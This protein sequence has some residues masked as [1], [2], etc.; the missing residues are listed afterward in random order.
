M[1]NRTASPQLEEG[2]TRI[3]NEL[4]DAIIRQQLSST[5]ISVLLAVIRKTYG[6]NKR[7][8][9]ISLTQLAA[10]CSINKAEASRSVKFLVENNIIVKRPV[11]GGFSLGVQKDYSKW[12]IV[13]ANAGEDANYPA[14][15]R[16]TDKH[17]TYVV[18]LPETGEFYIGV[19]TCKCSPAQDRYVGSGGWLSTI[20]KASLKKQVVGVFA[21]RE[22]A[23]KNEVA[24]IVEHRGNALIRNNR[25]YIE[26]KHIDL[27]LSNLTTGVSNLTTG[28]SES[29]DGVVKS[30]NKGLSESATTKDNP[31]DNKTKDKNLSRISQCAPSAFDAFWSIWLNKRDKKRARKAFDK[32]A[33]DAALLET[34]LAAVKAQNASA[35]WIEDGGKYIPH[36]TTWLNGERWN[37]EIKPIDGS[38]SAEQQAFVDTFN[39]NIGA[40]ALPVSE[41]SQQAADLITMAL[42]G[43]WGTD[44]EK[45]AGFWR[46]VRD[47]C[48]FKGQVSFEWLM[49]RDN[50]VKIRRGEFQPEGQQ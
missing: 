24:L 20:N 42:S 32:I 25:L 29:S 18:T 5:K 10:I 31:K 26:S 30:D 47:E 44:L 48:Q 16:N 11:E 2:Y 35:E 12:G 27:G 28:L 37:D 3:A 14:F 7:E 4:L 22:E 38:F 40:R 8:D 50:I 46:F 19:R 43:K 6:F 49:N 33:P 13:L 41:W 9:R 17:Y 36:A 21:T 1:T 34:M 39:A 15:D 23:E 45:W